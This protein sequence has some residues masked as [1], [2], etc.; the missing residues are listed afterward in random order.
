MDVTMIPYDA[1]VALA[2]PPDLLATC[3]GLDAGDLVTLAVEIQFVDGGFQNAAN[4]DAGSAQHEGTV[5]DPALATLPTL[6]PGAYKWQVQAMS[7]AG[8]ITD[9]TPYNNGDLAF[10]ICGAGTCPDTTGFVCAPT[11][12]TTDPAN[13]WACG[14]SC[15]D[16]WCDPAFPDGGQ[17]GSGGVLGCH[18][19]ASLQGGLSAPIIAASNQA[20]QCYF[21]AEANGVNSQ[22]NTVPIGAADWFTLNPL[23]QL[24]QA[25][26]ADQ[27]GAALAITAL[28][29]DAGVVSQ[30]LYFPN[31]GGCGTGLTV[32]LDT[33]TAPSA[34]HGVASDGT[35]VYV[36]IT[37]VVDVDAGTTDD[38]V[39]KIPIAAPVVQVLSR[40]QKGLSDI[41]YSPVAGKLFF[42]SR[43]GGTSANAI[44]SMGTDGSA[45]TPVVPAAPEAF[46]PTPAL[47]YS[48]T[49]GQPNGTLYWTSATGVYSNAGNNNKIITGIAAPLGITTYLEGVNH[50]DAVF[51]TTSDGKLM[52]WHRSNGVSDTLVTGQSHPAYP[53][54][55]VSSCVGG[56]C[57]FQMTWVTELAATNGGWWTIDFT[58]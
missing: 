33:E 17:P 58:N 55:Y 57:I 4:V 13:C 47:A 6:P 8:G 36:T 24:P 9:W 54:P 7:V 30:L 32:Q 40:N 5:A 20:S 43:G 29:N 18:I 52:E 44:F 45:P 34:Y 53:L 15:G 2:V 41:I 11:D 12:V 16:G 37:T 3:V 38:E 23:N 19:P 1:G 25:I 56:P 14:N 26:S 51:V 10:V 28:P 21:Y 46:G 48:P 27:N 50:S 42:I 39:W 35:N 49:N 31:D 22:S